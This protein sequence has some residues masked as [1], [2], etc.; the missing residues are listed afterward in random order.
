M[1]VKRKKKNAGKKIDPLFG[2][3]TERAKEGFRNRAAPR[4]AKKYVFFDE[5]SGEV[6]FEYGGI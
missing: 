2:D 6:V 1:D 5:K 3:E 4:K